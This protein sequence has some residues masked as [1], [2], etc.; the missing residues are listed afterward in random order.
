MNFKI[1]GIKYNDF[2]EATRRDMAKLRG[3][4]VFASYD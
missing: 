3:T 2:E 1:S 4:A